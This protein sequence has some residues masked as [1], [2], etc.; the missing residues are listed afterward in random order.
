MLFVNCVWPFTKESA[1]DRK[2]KITQNRIN[3]WLFCPTMFSEKLKKKWVFDYRYINFLQLYIDI[4]HVYSLKLLFQDYSD[5]YTHLFFHNTLELWKGI[6]YPANTG[7]LKQIN[8]IS[9][10]HLQFLCSPEKKK[11]NEN[12]TINLLWPYATFFHS[13]HWN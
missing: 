2:G 4:C 1:F 10:T 11:K 12:L 3:W 13:C 7:S 9:A 5:Y 8:I 6:L